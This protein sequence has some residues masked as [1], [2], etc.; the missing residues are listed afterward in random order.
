MDRNLEPTMEAGRAFMARGI[1]GS[2]VMLNLLQYR[3]I[4]DYART[5]ATLA[6]KAWTGAPPCPAANTAAS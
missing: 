2:V 1:T 5:P 4:A 3:A 6:A